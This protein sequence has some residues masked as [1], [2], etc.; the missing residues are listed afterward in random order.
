MREGRGA[1]EVGNM[2]MQLLKHK[3]LCVGGGSWDLGSVVGLGGGRTQ[4]QR[5]NIAV[6]SCDA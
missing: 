5:E 2:F 1:R 3:H 4:T 6:G